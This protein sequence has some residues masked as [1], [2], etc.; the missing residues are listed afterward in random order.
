MTDLGAAEPS[1]PTEPAAP[2]AD[3]DVTI[4]PADAT[5]PDAELPA[6]P[7]GAGTEAPDEARRRR[8]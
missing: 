2:Y 5:E 1:G 8:L 6:P 4:E 3:E 7:A